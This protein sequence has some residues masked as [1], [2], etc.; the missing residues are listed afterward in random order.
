VVELDRSRN[1]VA[2]H[3]TDD[4]VGLPKDPKMAQGL[5]FHIMNYRARSIG[6]RLEIE[7][8]KKGGTRVSCYLPQLK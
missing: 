4:G 3:V 5:G 8:P 2:L 7:S 6:S 1:G